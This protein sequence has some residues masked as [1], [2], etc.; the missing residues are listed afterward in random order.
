MFDFR[1][2]FEK[3]TSGLVPLL[4]CCFG[5]FWFFFLVVCFCFVLFSCQVTFGVVLF[6]YVYKIAD[7]EATSVSKSSQE[8]Y[9]VLLAAVV[10]WICEHSFLG[11]GDFA[12]DL[13]AG[14]AYQSVRYK[15][16]FNASSLGTTVLA[17]TSYS[18]KS[19]V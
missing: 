5:G 2:K 3:T 7:V 17:S 15:N 13:L 10:K 8:S 14:F 11:S 6:L 18:F 19:E 12:H 4:V 16:T 1:S 9:L